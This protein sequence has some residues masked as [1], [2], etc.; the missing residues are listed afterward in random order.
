MTRLTR[1]MLIV[2]AITAFLPGC[3]DYD[4]SVNSHFGELTLSVSADAVLKSPSGELLADVSVTP[5]NDVT[6][7]M[8]DVQGNYRHTWESLADFPEGE[9]YF[10][11][12]Y[13]IT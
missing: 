13:L 10:V 6:V 2:I 4:S 5:P 1:I 12:T 3:S 9:R 11:G 8:S 7:T